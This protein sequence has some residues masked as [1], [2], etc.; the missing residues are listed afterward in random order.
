[1]YFPLDVCSSTFPCSYCVQINLLFSILVTLNVCIVN[2]QMYMWPVRV[3]QHKTCAHDWRSKLLGYLTGRIICISSAYPIIHYNIVHR[4]TY[5]DCSLNREETQRDRSGRHYITAF[6]SQPNNPS[7][8]IVHL[9][10]VLPNFNFSVASFFLLFQ[11]FLLEA[12]FISQ[13]ASHGKP[14]VRLLVRKPPVPFRCGLANL[15]AA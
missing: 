10:P 6:E 3:R 14:Y 8:C 11:S 13:I 12:P 5:F 7:T 4:S 15:R 2:F 9:P 1:M